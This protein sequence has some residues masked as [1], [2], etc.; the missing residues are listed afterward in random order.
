M[1]RWP[2]L[3]IPLHPRCGRALAGALLCLLTLDAAA[4][5]YTSASTAF[6]L[7]DSST[8]TKVGYNTAPYKFNAAAGC[9]TAPPALDDV[10]S[11]PIPI[12]FTFPYGSNTYTTA[13]IMSNGRLQFGNT[14]CGYGTASTGPPQTYPYGY[15]DASM[16]ATMKVFDVDLDL[17]NLVDSPGYPSPCASS[18]TCYVSVATIGTAPTRQFVVSWKNVPEWVSASNTS[19][20]FDLQIILNEDGS[21]VYQYGTIIHGGTGTAQIGWQLSTSDYQVLS[22]GA[23]LE[24]PPN[25]AIVFYMPTPV[26][27]YR[28]DEG[29][30]LPGVAGQV[31]DSSGYANH[32]SSV[33]AAQESSDGKVCRGANIPLNTSASQVD[34]VRLVDIS[35]AALN[36]RGSGTVAFW[37]KANAAWVGGQAAQLLDATTVNGEWFYLTRTPTGTLY[38]AVKDST[39]VLRTV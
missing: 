27:A 21:F 22:F 31:L 9:G 20:S 23:S 15:P 16:N 28:F 35:N 32:G 4:Q 29:A 10:L 12:G 30:W 1:L 2:V 8:H 13:Y 26:A 34:A 33:G 38:F 25:T 14:T 5:T 17:T 6:N 7:I 36:L 18:A 19:G 11:D 24:P 3:R 39:G 37:Y